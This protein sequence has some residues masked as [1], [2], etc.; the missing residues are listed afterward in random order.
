MIARW[1]DFWAG[2][3]MS[4]LKITKAHNQVRGRPNVL[5]PSNQVTGSKQHVAIIQQL[6]VSGR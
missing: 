5:D 3:C 2:D 4:E 6:K 1:S